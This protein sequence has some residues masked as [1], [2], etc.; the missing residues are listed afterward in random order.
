M[1]APSSLVR[2]G[3][4]GTPS[5]RA[6]LRMPSAPRHFVRRPRL[7]R[8][9]DDLSEYPGTVGTAPAGAGKTTLAADWSRYCGRPCGWLAL[10]TSD[11][12]PAQL[13]HS[14]GTALDSLMGEAGSATRSTLVIDDVDRIDDDPRARAA[15]SLFVEHRPPSVHLLLLSRR[16]PPLAVDRLRAGGQL[17]DIDF[18]ALRFSDIE[19]ADL[20]VTLC[21]D[22]SAADLAAGV[23][24]AGGWAA[25]LQ[26]TALW[27]RSHR[28]SPASTG[29]S[30]SV[31]LGRLVDDYLW[32]E[33]VGSESPEIVAL[34]LSAAV[35][36]RIN[37]GLAE[38]L[39]RHP[40]AGELLER[41]DE[42]G[43]FLTRLDDGPWFEMH[44]LVADMLTA[45]FARRWPEAL[46]EQHARAAEWFEGVGDQ[47]S[48]LDHWLRADRPERALR[49]LAGVAMHL[50]ETDRGERL[51]R[52]LDQ[53]PAELPGTDPESA[54]RYAWC[55]LVAGRDQLPNALAVARTTCK[56]APPPVQARLGVLLAAQRARAGDWESGAT[57]ARVSLDR[58]PDHGWS[59]PIGRFGWRLLARATALDERWDDDDATVTEA[60]ATLSAD[61]DDH[62]SFES[63]RALGLAMAGCP[64]DARRVAAAVRQVVGR[65][66]HLALGSELALVDALVTRE[67]G[68]RGGAHAQLQS[69]IDG[70]RTAPI[71][72]RL[73]AHLELVELHLSGGLVDSAETVFREALALHD[74]LPQRDTDAPASR[75][76]EPESA[77]VRFV[78]RVGVDLA[79][80]SDDPDAARRWSARMT[81]PFWRHLCEARVES[82]SGRPEAAREAL[83][84]AQ[85]RC[86]RH[87]VLMD[88][89]GARTLARRDREAAGDAVARAMATAARHGMLQSVATYGADLV[90]LA[91]LQAWCVPDEWMDRLR[92]A[93]VPVWVSREAR[94]PIDELTERERDVL[95]LL[96]SRLT[97][98]EIA[99]EL[100]VTPNTLKF[101][102]RAIYRKF[103]VASR[104]AAV[105]SA[106]QMRLLPGG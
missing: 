5:F 27:I 85:P 61:V 60:R 29:T 17:A 14:L 32:G 20:L 86:P 47:L 33:V 16:R 103:G 25:A 82:A 64:E 41:A 37:S 101:H 39:T 13:A 69:L 46:R 89:A 106:R 1:T 24:R 91:E 77:L 34:V 40:D 12:E 90:E 19:A 78:S 67:T 6:K 71:E 28:Y 15:L 11:R 30:V 92:H 79:L 23:R 43:L 26:L 88:L 70:P 10:D 54:V 2:S 9:L 94:G 102:L 31:G 76:Q 44:A 96:P 59:D 7:T 36:G 83:T 3:R 4:L 100:Y 62:W 50:V 93:L 45:R 63:T 74:G 52:A 81:D 72:S 51:S 48:A 58:L 75:G 21:P 42:R 49:A 66:R 98:R 38:A 53:I 68:D 73:I 8:L 22:I 35:V 87:Q 65:R 18:E 57:R 104:A 105:E 55:H 95:R 84:R 99:A 97:V 80:A 56:A